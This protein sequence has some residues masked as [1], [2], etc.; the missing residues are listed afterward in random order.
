MQFFKEFID[1]IGERADLKASDPP[2]AFEDRLIMRGL[3]PFCLRTISFCGHQACALLDSTTVDLEAVFP[4]AV[5][6]PEAHVFAPV[7]TLL[8]PL[9]D[10]E[11][12]ARVDS[13]PDRAS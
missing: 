3:H 5:P 11:L 12:F 6:V 1:G 9:H 2:P 13:M 10:T 7:S 4:S 8:H